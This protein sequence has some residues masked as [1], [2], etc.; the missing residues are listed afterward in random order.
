MNFYVTG[1]GLCFGYAYLGSRAKCPVN[2]DNEW[3]YWNLG[4][5]NAEAGI[6]ITPAPDRNVPFCENPGEG[7]SSVGFG[8][9]T[10]HDFQRE[11][12]AKVEHLY[13]SGGR[14]FLKTNMPSYVVLDGEVKGGLDAD[15]EFTED[16]N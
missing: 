12:W 3:K 6:T 13:G 16:M 2:A 8:S 1:R 4:S 14:A 11:V 15:C 7:A 10:D 9:I 5:W